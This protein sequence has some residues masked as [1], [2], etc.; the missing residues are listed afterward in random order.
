VERIIDIG[1]PTPTGSGYYASRGDNEVV[2]LS[3][4]GLD[5]LIGFATNPPYLETE[6]LLPSTPEADSTP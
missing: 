4:S 2:I 1:V 5:P 3:G 6:T